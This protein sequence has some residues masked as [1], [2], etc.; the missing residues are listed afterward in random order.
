MNRTCRDNGY[1]PKPPKST[2]S[3]GKG[4]DPG[5]NSILQSTTRNLQLDCLN[6]A[7]NSLS[8]HDQDHENRSPKRISMQQILH[9]ENYIFPKRNI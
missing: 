4:S 6:Y 7:I 8:I 5:T 9:A 1:K 2:G 3:G